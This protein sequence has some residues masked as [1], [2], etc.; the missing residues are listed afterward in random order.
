MQAEPKP[1]ESLLILHLQ[2]ALQAPVAAII[3]NRAERKVA[4]QES[5]KT[6]SNTW[7]D[8]VDTYASNEVLC[9]PH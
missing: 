8:V 6:V 4:Y 1:D 2:S 5:K 7:Q 3:A 9:N